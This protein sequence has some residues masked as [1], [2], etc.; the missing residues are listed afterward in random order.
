MGALRWFFED[1]TTGRIVIAQAP[2]LWLWLFIAAFAA[3][4]VVTTVGSVNVIVRIV[5]YGGFAIWAV[6]EVV[7]GVNPWRKL[8]GVATICGILFL[9]LKM[10]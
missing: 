6:D 1:R 5:E 7:R 2:N 4:Y 9:L 10:A 8:I 3:S